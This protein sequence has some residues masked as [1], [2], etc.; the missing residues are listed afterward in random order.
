MQVFF[1]LKNWDRELRNCLFSLSNIL[2][3]KIRFQQNV[4]FITFDAS[5][6][7]NVYDGVFLCRLHARFRKVCLF[8]FSLKGFK[9][10]TAAY[11]GKKGTPS[12]A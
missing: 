6:N 3:S 8:A 4:P 10:I 9:A 5:M 11:V 7:I 12:L 1:I 2:L